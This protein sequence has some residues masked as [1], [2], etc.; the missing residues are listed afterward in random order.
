MERR[1][2]VLGISPSGEV[3]RLSGAVLIEMQDEWLAG[4]RRSLSE[5]SMATLYNPR[6]SGE[7]AAIEA[8][9]KFQESPHPARAIS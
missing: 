3:I 6:N 9:G 8:A 4:D 7:I 5:S 2:R 1:G